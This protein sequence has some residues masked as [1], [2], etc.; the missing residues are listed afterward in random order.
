M[1]RMI[2]VIAMA[3]LIA[4]LSAQGALAGWLNSATV[5]GVGEGSGSIY[6]ILTDPNATPT[7]IDSRWYVAD[8]ANQNTILAI[9]LTASSNGQKVQVGLTDFAQYGT[10]TAIYIRNDI[11]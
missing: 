9:A 8:P 5:V 10:V 1:K 7:P 4:G 11:Q 2:I 6:L 3:C